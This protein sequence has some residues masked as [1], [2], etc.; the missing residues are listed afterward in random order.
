MHMDISEE[1]VYARIYNENVPGQGLENLGGQALCE[2]AQSKGTWTCHKSHSMREFTVKMPVTKIGAQ[3]MRACAV[4]TRMD[5]SQ[6]FF[7]RIYRKKCRGPRSRC[8]VRASP[9]NRNAHGHVTRAISC[10]NLQEKCR[11]QDR[12]AQFTWACHK[13]HFIRRIYRK[14]AGDQSAYPDLTPA[15]TSIL[16]TH[17]CEHIVWGIIPFSSIEVSQL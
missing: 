14:N 15:S 17:Q 8:T 1:A 4:E 10:E 12:D 6:D 16:R 7:A 3:F 5:M 13:S 11:D 2:P 9:R